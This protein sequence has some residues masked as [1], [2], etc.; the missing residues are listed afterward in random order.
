[1][2][3]RYVPVPRDRDLVLRR[4]I[5]A[6]SRRYPRYGYRLVTRIL[7]REG[8]RV[9]RKRVHRI[10]RREGL[11][12]PQVQHKKRRLG[13][14]GNGISRR[15]PEHVGHVWGLDFVYDE[16]EDGRPLRLLTV[17]DEYSRFNLALEVRRSFRSVDVIAVL[18]EL[19][20]Q[21]G[22]PEHIRCDNG[23]EFIAKALQRWLRGRS[24]EALYIEPG[25]PWE[26]GFTESFN[27]T[28]RNE[29][30]DRE[31]FTSLLEAKVLAAR[32]RDEYNCER[33][34]SSLDDQTPAE[35]K[36][37]S[38]GSE[39][40]E[41]PGEPKTDAQNRS[42]TNATRSGIHVDTPEIMVGLS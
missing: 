37:R 7:R 24:V 4:R 17:L 41:S 6:L 16:T 18:E 22:F 28:L 19:V 1:M 5:L 13:Q 12:V 29:L 42:L 23:P 39:S 14:S 40:T 32:Y 3:T 25:S 30:L 20:Q 27:G 38:R 33:P 10:W 21:Y 9:N 36:A 8:W 2:T 35:A 15:R 26:N 11:Q 34:H 31:I